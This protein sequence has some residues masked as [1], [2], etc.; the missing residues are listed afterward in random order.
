MKTITAVTIAG[1]FLATAAQADTINF[2]D[3]TPGAVP[4]GWTDTQTGSG[5][6]KWLVVADNTAPS[7]PNVLKQSGE[8][9]YHS[10]FSPSAA[11]LRWSAVD[12]IT[13]A[14]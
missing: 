5:S 1:S 8:A 7:K 11:A 4:P 6:P 12:A 2:D 3:A 14:G 9:T 10:N 13:P